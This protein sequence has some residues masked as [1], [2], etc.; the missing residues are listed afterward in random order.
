MIIDL[1]KESDLTNVASFPLVCFLS[2]ANSSVFWSYFLYNK[3]MKKEY[4]SFPETM[5]D[6]AEYNK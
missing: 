1:P 6:I 5:A 4:D 2:I 3:S